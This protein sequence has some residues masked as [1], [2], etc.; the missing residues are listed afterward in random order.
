MSTLPKTRVN[1]IPIKIPTT[2]F[3]ELDKIIPKFVC[4]RRSQ[5]DKAILR[6][7]NKAGGIT[8]PDFKMYYKPILFKT[9]W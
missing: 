6:K 9:V 4:N 8:V 2:F 5:I 1:E 3:T 7:N